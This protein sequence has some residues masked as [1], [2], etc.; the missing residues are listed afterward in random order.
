MKFRPSFV[1]LSLLILSTGATRAQA[2]TLL[3]RGRYLV[4]SIAACG[5]CH[6]PQGPNGP[7]AGKVLGGGMEM[8]DPAFKAY[9]SNITPDPETGIGRWT[10]AQI[11]T[12]VREGK[13][14]DGTTIGPPMP[15]AQYRGMSDRDAAAI[16]A[17]LRSVPAIKNPVPKST[18][19]FP[20]PAHYGPAL[21]KVPSP[22]TA[23]KIAY[24]RYL[25]GPLGHCIECHSAPGANGAPDA[26]HNLGTGGVRFDGPW[27]TSVST[28]ITPSNLA[29]YS[30]AELRKLITTGVR[31]DG[32]HLK[33]P[34]GTSHY[35]RMR[36]GDMGALIAY[37]RQL[38]SK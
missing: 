36:D 1:A 13:R 31:P 9:A 3:E 28:N 23:D 11:I 29:R 7:V 14:P 2:E 26:V 8:A 5:N 19:R 32:S 16:A 33:P 38:P 30:D 37:L 35:A 20:L 18:Y 4:R 6:T 10:S 21:G 22:P 25:A 15:I 27:G 12:A 17:Y 24:G 34:M